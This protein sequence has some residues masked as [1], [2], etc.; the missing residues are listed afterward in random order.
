[1]S[2]ISCYSPRPSCEFCSTACT[3]WTGSD[4]GQRST[5]LRRPVLGTCINP[6]CCS[7]VSVLPPKIPTFPGLRDADASGNHPIPSFSTDLPIFSPST[8][9]RSTQTSSDCCVCWDHKHHFIYY[10]GKQCVIQQFRWIYLVGVSLQHFNSQSH[11]MS[12][13]STLS[14]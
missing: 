11:T 4:R 14:I 12:S 5:K 7:P 2:T 10:I 3:Q 6:P 1:M 9:V 8:H 13:S